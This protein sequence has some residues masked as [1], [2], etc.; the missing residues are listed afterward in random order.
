MV[1]PLASKPVT[2]SLNVTVKFI[3]KV[4]VDSLCPAARVIIKVGAGA[5]N[6]IS[7]LGNE[8]SLDISPAT[9]LAASNGISI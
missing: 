4:I 2:S 1:I 3:G 6:V 8:G 9:L 7:W 5:V